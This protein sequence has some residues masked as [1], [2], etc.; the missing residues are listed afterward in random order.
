[1]AVQLVPTTFVYYLIISSFKCECG[2]I[3]ASYTT[4][5]SPAATVSDSAAC[6]PNEL[7]RWFRGDPGSALL[8]PSSCEY[9]FPLSP[10]LVSSLLQEAV[11]QRLPDAEFC[12]PRLAL[13]W[14]V[15]RYSL[16]DWFITPLRRCM[17]NSCSQFVGHYMCP[18]DSELVSH[19]GLRQLISLLGSLFSEGAHEREERE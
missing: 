14:V 4:T 15:P 2:Y 19:F 12:Y 8:I 18:K 9:P 13:G 16:R 17:V 3:S 7:C 6:Q 11:I 10:R 1:M 5:C